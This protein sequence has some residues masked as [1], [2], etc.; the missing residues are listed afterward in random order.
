MEF[1]KKEFVNM[2]LETV[3]GTGFQAFGLG[4][5]FLGVYVLAAAWDLG[6]GGWGMV[7]TCVGLFDAV[8]TVCPLSQTLN[9]NN[10]KTLRP[11]NPEPLTPNP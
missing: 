8:R 11:Y 10:P 6:L 5:L 9:L 7:G 4:L 3:S 2:F 1:L